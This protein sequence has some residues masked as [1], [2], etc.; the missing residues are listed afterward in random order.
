MVNFIVNKIESIKLTIKLM[1]QTCLISFNFIDRVCS[2][3]NIFINYFSQAVGT[4]GILDAI[5]SLTSDFVLR[6]N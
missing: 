1:D 4:S 5:F 2:M 3:V 6:Q